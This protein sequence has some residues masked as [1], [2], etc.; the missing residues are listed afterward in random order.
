MLPALQKGREDSVSSARTR[1]M[2]TLGDGDTSDNECDGLLESTSKPETP[3]EEVRSP[4][5][6]ERHLESKKAGVKRYHALLEL[7]STEVGYLLDLR[8]LVSVSLC[9]HKY[10]IQSAYT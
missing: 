5:D 8:A 7:L 10:S 9:C 4:D 6:D 3:P 2:F 1:P